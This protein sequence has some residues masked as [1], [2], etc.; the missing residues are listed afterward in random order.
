MVEILRYQI[1][2]ACLVLFLQFWYIALANIDHIK[3]Y[4]LR[5][6]GESLVDTS[7][8]N[9][10]N[11]VVISMDIVIRYLPL[12]AIIALGMYALGSVLLRVYNMADRP[13]AAHPL[14]LQRVTS[15]FAPSV[16]QSPPF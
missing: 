12:W 3:S 16:Q 4:L 2:L 6:D 1:F 7:N 10:N 11:V 9:R 5:L 15:L 8:N 14:K 13:D